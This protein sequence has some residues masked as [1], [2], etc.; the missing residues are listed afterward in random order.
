MA[1]ETNTPESQN[2]EKDPVLHHWYV[3]KIIIKNYTG[4][5]SLDITNSFLR[6][7]LTSGLSLAFISGMVLVEEFS[8][9]RNYMPLVGNETIEITIK[10]VSEESY[11]KKYRVVKIEPSL[12]SPSPTQKFYSIKFVS[13]P[14][15]QNMKRSFSRSF[16][17]LPGTKIVK[18]IYDDYLKESDGP[19]I[20]IPFPPNINHSL[21]IPYSKPLKA[22]NFVS[23]YC[24]RE[25]N[26]DY[27]FYEDF[28][29]IYFLPI[30]E[31]KKID[32][33]V[34]LFSSKDPDFRGEETN[35]QPDN[36]KRRRR[37]NKYVFDGDM[38]DV[39][40]NMREGKYAATNINFDMT[41]KKVTNRVY[42]YEK[43]FLKQ[44]TVGASPTVSPQASEELGVENTS[45]I[46][47]SFEPS[48]AYDNRANTL[49]IIN[50]KFRR[51]S[52]NN[53]FKQIITVNTNS[54]FELQ[55]GNM[56]T[57]N[58]KTNQVD[59]A[60]KDNDPYVSG[61]YMILMISHFFE[62][63]KSKTTIILGRDSIEESL[64]T[65]VEL[66]E[67]DAQ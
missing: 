1:Q 38:Y 10:S 53:M 50:S 58:V 26:Y 51:D 67:G 15:F 6:L 21:T 36:E 42:L 2:T 33:I 9:F 25:D 18:T 40:K 37:M 17:N 62:K 3:D 59:S 66:E 65:E 22:I 30:S 12:D 52:V 29:G 39:E 20:S 7:E 61:K 13:G 4:Q 32:P 44:K 54:W 14:S 41:L 48:L 16:K 43:E 31:L 55:P 47:V 11:T 56:V 28:N 19:E 5:A 57:V 46:V 27:V 60:E 34:E 49:N 23:K 24:V 63:S 8:N 64:P 35:G 45:R